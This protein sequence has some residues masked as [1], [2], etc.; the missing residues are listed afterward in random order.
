MYSFYASAILNVVGWGSYSITLVHT[1][2]SVPSHTK[3]FDLFTMAPGG[4]RS[5]SVVECLTRD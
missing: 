1:S 2:R 4:E 5:G 3:T